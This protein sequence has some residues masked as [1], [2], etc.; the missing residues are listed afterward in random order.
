MKHTTKTIIAAIALITLCSAGFNKPSK[1]QRRKGIMNVDEKGKITF[2]P[3]EDWA[4]FTPVNDTL[5]QY[6]VN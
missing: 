2:Q 3:L 5:Y 6:K 4:D 1:V